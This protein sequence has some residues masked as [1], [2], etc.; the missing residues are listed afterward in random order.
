M[1]HSCNKILAGQ[2]QG[3]NCGC[4]FSDL[5]WK[6]EDI[7]TKWKLWKSRHVIKVFPSQNL[8]V[9]NQSFWKSVGAAAPNPPTLTRRLNDIHYR[10]M[11]AQV[12]PVWESTKTFLCTTLSNFKTSC[13]ISR[14]LTSWLIFLPLLKALHWYTVLLFTLPTLGYQ[15]M[16]LQSLFFLSLTYMPYL[17]PH[18]SLKKRDN[19]FWEFNL[20]S[21]IFDT[22][23]DTGSC[24]KNF[25]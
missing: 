3:H 1:L 11:S 16:V 4:R 5:L 20:N 6:A 25:Q 10:S 9:Q 14:V 23:L 2:W 13:Q 7:E 15:T 8:W 21:R 19:Q 18:Y 22:P 12:L 17:I 24:I